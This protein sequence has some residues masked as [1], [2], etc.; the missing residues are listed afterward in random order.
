M[1]FTFFI[2]GG[3]AL[4]AF[5][6]DL[7]QRPRPISSLIPVSGY[8]FP[9]GHALISIIFFTSLIYFFKDNIK[10]KNLR[11]TFITINIL[12]FLLIGFSRIYLNVHWF[13]DVLG[14]FL[15]GL[16]WIGFSIL[17]FKIIK[18]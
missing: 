17:F 12:L 2:I 15:L 1:I 8:S 18:K 9:S 7:I 16:F 3:F 10:N 6:K 4:K 5:V 13:S 14:G 11:Y